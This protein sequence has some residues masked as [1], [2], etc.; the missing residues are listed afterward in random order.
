[1]PITTQYPVLPN[2]LSPEEQYWA[3]K[4]A[5]VNSPSESLG[6]HINAL[7]SVNGHVGQALGI[8]PPGASTSPMPSFGGPGTQ[9]EIQEKQQADAEA[10]QQQQNNQIVPPALQESIKGAKIHDNE[11]SKMLDLITK[12]GISPLTN[13]KAFLE[14]FD[15]TSAQND[16]AR[17]W[18]PLEGIREL[19]S[20]KYV[21][22]KAR[23][24]GLVDM[25]TFLTKKA[26]EEM[27][28]GPNTVGEAQHLFGNVVPLTPE[29]Q[30]NQVEGPRT[31]PSDMGPQPG[32][33]DPNTPLTLPQQ[34]GITNPLMKGMASGNL[35]RTPEGLVPAYV[36]AMGPRVVSSDVAQRAIDGILPPGP[37]GQPQLVVPPGIHPVPFI[38][39]LMSQAASLRKA[40]S[41]DMGDALESLSMQQTGKR[42]AQ[43][44]KE[45]PALA[46]QLRNQALIAEKKDIYAYQQDQQAQRQKDVAGPIRTAQMEAERDQPVT[47][48]QLWRDPY[49]GQAASATTTTRE[50]QNSHMVKLRPDQVETINQLNSIDNGLEVVK[51]IS[52]KVLSPKADSPA[53][54]ILRSLGQTAYL[55][56]LRATGDPDMTLMDSIVSRLTA[57]LVKSQ[58]DTANIAVAER[59]MFAQA[60]VNNQ[61]STEAV[62]GNLDN[63]MQMTQGVRK[64]MGFKTRTELVESLLR[65]G[66]NHD[67]VKDALK[68]RGL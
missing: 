44:A 62:L 8:V 48:P 34:L 47:E 25:G 52:K 43:V 40:Q 54:E 12:H 63:V 27:T 37:N 65:S 3:A 29:Q 11:M 51:Q 5:R 31:S 66:M 22:L 9:Q 58:G 49:T 18:G 4:A 56:Y 26:L 36:A 19:V 24:Q 60:L 7:Q 35:M 68:K 2:D 20:P 17:S 21:A 1:M 28:S 32:M 55:K 46:E 30:A 38:D 23:Q 64:L 16:M 33:V 14:H 50:A 57:P 59:E 61:A 41:P 15:A 42:F 13:P 10:Q 45:N 53:G 6:P 67:Q 39:T